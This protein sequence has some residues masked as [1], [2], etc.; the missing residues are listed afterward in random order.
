LILCNSFEGENAFRDS[1][2]NTQVL[3]GIALA[4][5][6]FVTLYGCFYRRAQRARF[7]HLLPPQFAYLCAEKTTTRILEEYKWHLV[8]LLV[9]ADLPHLTLENFRD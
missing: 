7:L 3:D 5:E 9:D 6:P 4:C 1:F 2:V 8:D